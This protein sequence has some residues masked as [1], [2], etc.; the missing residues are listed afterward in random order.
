M[1]SSKAVTVVRGVLAT[2]KEALRKLEARES[3]DSLSMRGFIHDRDCGQGE[4]ATTLAKLEVAKGA[5]TT[6]LDNFKRHS[7]IVQLA[8]TVMQ[9]CMK[10]TCTVH[11]PLFTFR[12]YSTKSSKAPG[13][14][15]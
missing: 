4:L 6:T 15:N 5:L 11:P 10:F 9:D 13:L 2:E 3:A 12:S 7:S 1:E 8:E 14:I